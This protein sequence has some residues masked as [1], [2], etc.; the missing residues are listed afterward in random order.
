VVRAP[1][2]PPRADRVWRGARET[3]TLGCFAG[4]DGESLADALT[5]AGR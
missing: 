3:L 2:P 1:G 5:I 4:A